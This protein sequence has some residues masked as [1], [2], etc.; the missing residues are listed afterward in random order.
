[1]ST[2]LIKNADIV[3]LNAAGDIFKGSDLWISGD[4]IQ[5][6]G[7]SNPELKADEIIDGTGLVA[8]PGFWNAHTHAAMTFER[9]YGDDLPLDR[10]FNEKIWFAESALT[11]ADVLL[12]AELAA[13]EMIRSGTMGFADHYFYMGRV[14]D[15]VEKSG[16]K[17]LL[18]WCVFGLPSEV[19]TDLKGA[20]EFT[21]HYQNSANGRIKT[22]LGPHAPYT[23]PPEFLRKIAEVAQEERLGFHIHLAESDDQYQNSLNKHGQSPVFFLN[24]LGLFDAP[25]QKIAAHCIALDKNDIELLAHKGVSAVQCPGCHMKLGMGVTPVPAMLAS[26]VNVALGTDGAASNNNLDMLEEARLAALLQ[27]MHTRDAT[28]LA[29]DIPLR[30]A[31]QYG[32]RAMGFENSGQIIPGA[33]ADIV[34]FDFKRPHLRPRHSVLGNLL[35]SAQSADIRHSMIAGR[36]VMKDFEILTLDEERILKEAEQGAFAMLARATKTLRT[37]DQ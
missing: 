23:C 34:F 5:S 12:G 10:W 30:M 3:T 1:M 36:F 9:S 17:A 32:A 14:A 7:P 31:T 13:A 6:I 16:L 18:S 27:K 25:G 28:V 21:K 8:M 26:G 20:V 22:C 29:G 33:A 37:Y 2:I 11:E 24:S 4:T 19:G 35:Y 15:V